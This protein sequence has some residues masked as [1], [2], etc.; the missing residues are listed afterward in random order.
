MTTL[1]LNGFYGHSQKNPCTVFVYE[2]RNG[3]KWYCVEGSLTVNKT[4]E[5][6]G[7]G[8]W[9]EELADVDCFTWSNPI[10]DMDEFIKAVED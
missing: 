3:S 9:V 4:F 10:N 7:E 1:E 5:D 6:M 8:V 2:N